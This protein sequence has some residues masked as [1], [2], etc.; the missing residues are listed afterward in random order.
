MTDKIYIF[1]RR[2]L[3]M[4]RGKEIAQ[5]CHAVLWLRCLAYFPV[6]DCPV[7]TLKAQSAKDLQKIRRIAAVN[8]LTNFI[9]RDAG[10]TEVKRGTPTCIAVLGAPGGSQFDEWELY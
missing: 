9:V 2:D 1:M 7:L 6:Y 3:K 5:A 10:M 8:N 4:R